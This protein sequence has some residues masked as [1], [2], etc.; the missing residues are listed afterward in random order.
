MGVIHFKSTQ[1][2]MPLPILYLDWA[3]GDKGGERQRNSHQDQASF[4][5][6]SQATGFQEKTISLVFQLI[7]KNTQL[8][9]SLASVSVCRGTV[10]QQDSFPCENLQGLLFSKS[11]LVNALNA[12]RNKGRQPAQQKTE[13][14]HQGDPCTY[15]L[16]I[17]TNKQEAD[18][19]P[20]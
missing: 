6:Q 17:A 16:Q 10:S 11:T 12:T 18:P 14:N 13:K 5:S 9:K 1:R 4:S 15:G 2:R 20:L 19:G 8:L 3:Q 7:K